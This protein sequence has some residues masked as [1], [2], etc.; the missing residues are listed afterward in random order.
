MKVNVKINIHRPSRII[1]DHGLDKDG[2]V[3]RYLRDEVERMSN[4]YIPFQ[5]GNLRRLKSH[6]S[7][8]EIK[9]TAPYAKFIYYGKLMLGKNG[10]AWVRYG[11]RK[12][13]TSKN[14]KYHTSGTGPKW[15]QKMLQKEGNTLR[16]NVEN[17]IKRGGR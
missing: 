4:K 13:V 6:P 3:T 5:N 9:Y 17:Y 10:S 14:L 1:K 12:Y 2:K 15:E 11:E 7:N 16:K 8:H